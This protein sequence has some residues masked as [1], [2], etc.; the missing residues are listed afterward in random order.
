[1]R[2][3]GVLFDMDGLL[4]DTERVALN[5]FERAAQHFGLPDIGEMA[6]QL[7]GLREDAVKTLVTEALDQ[8]VD[9]QELFDRWTT[10]FQS[11]LAAGIN[12]KP[13]ADDL[14]QSLRAMG[15]P[16]AVATST[17]TRHAKTHLRS[18]GLAGYFQ[19]ITG[20]DQVENG[21]PAPDIYH[22]AAASLGLVASDCVAFE[23]SDPG[24]IAAV[25]S[26]ATTVQI[27]DILKSGDT[28]AS[29][30]HT[31]APDLLAGA[32]QIGLLASV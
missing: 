22:K 16:C 11:E 32:R 29:L 4:L 13:G 15:L 10:L 20:G 9:F 17:A 1:M 7:I 3:Q 30:G 19:T 26:G 2:W 6:P 27:P 5:C 12:L 24:V 21:K 23:D 18:A 31:I 8:R 14:L 28:V 25:G